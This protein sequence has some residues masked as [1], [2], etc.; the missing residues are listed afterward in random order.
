M[1]SV[2]VFFFFFKQKTA[3]EMLRSL[4]GSEMCI[5]DRGDED[6]RC[7]VLMVQCVDVLVQA[8]LLVM[9]LVPVKVEQ[10]EHDQRAP[11]VQH[12]FH[13]SRGVWGQEF[14][15]IAL[16]Q[17]ERGVSSVVQ[18]GT[19]GRELPS[20]TGRDVEQERGELEG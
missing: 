2:C 3:Y 9:H 7:V 15:P 5:R 16:E 18:P 4:V 17:A 6:E 1:G 14:V 8:P 13:H 12:H 20:N 11:D 10:V 19:P